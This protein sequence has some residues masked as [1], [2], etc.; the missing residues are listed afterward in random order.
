MTALVAHGFPAAHPVVQAL[1]LL[2][3]LGVI[4]AGSVLAAV[5]F[6]SIATATAAVVAWLFEPK[7]QPPLTVEP[8]PLES[9]ASPIPLRVKVW[10]H[11]P[12]E[13][14]VPLNPLGQSEADVSMRS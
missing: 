14:P 5:L 2:A 9:Y 1:A 12:G 3:S 4:V 13:L 10:V 11:H 8:D 7:K 6:V